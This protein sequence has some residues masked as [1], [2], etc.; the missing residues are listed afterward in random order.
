MKNLNSSISFHSGMLQF[1]TRLL[2][3]VESRFTSVERISSYVDTLPEEAPPTISGSSP[4][5]TWPEHGEKEVS[6]AGLYFHP[7]HVKLCRWIVINLVI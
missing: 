6:E 7:R 2:A 1:T 5:S 4:P 3:D